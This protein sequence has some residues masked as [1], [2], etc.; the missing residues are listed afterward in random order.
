MPD[1][2]SPSPSPEAPSQP[3]AAASPENF[4]FDRPVERRG[5]HSLKWDMM[6]RLYGLSPEE[7]LPMWV[8]DMD[9]PAAPPIRAAIERMAAH[10][11]YGYYG[12]DS[13]LRDALIWWQRERHGW[14]VPR[15]AIVHVNGLVNGT[16][17]AVDAFTAPG[18][19]VLLFTPVY[20]A[21]ARVIRAGGR[22][23]VEV[24]MRRE[25]GRYRMDME[26]A[27]TAIARE[28]VRM[29]ILCSPHNPGG[30][31]W[32]QEELGELADLA[33]HHDVV[34]L[35]DEIHDDLV[36]PPHRH[37]PMALAAPHI[38]DRLVTMISATKTF[39]IAGGHVGQVIITDPALRAR[40]AERMTALGISPGAFGMVAA[41]AAWSPEGAAWL[42][43][44]M[45]YLD[46]NRRLFDAG[47]S[48]IP[49]VVSMPLEATYLAWVDF[50]GTGMDQTEIVERVERRAKIATNHGPQFGSGGEGFMRFNLAMSRIRIE[51]AVARLQD[52]FADLQ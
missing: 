11:V 8:A 39:N 52:A 28:N 37:V 20:H 40:Y 51:E 33:R 35:S 13:S 12:D 15:E 14:D 17:I 19:G 47:V 34:L 30:R 21:F 26:A 25:E 49:G 7:G 9:F 5:T 50:S 31:V 1:N 45:A 32:S 48:A 3:N 43:A 27:E 42:D 23:L 46:E 6:E 22:N 44:L 29:V 38:A 24:P 41:E 18:E 36:F 2:S 16:A 4:D 10:G